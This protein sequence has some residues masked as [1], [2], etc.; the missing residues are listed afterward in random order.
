MSL[1]NISIIAAFTKLDYAVLAVYLIAVVALGIWMGPVSYT[2][3][4]AHE[5]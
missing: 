4:R 3:L 1:A 2:H 5:T